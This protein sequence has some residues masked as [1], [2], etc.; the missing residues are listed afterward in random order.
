M[1]NSHL[2]MSKDSVRGRLVSCLSA[3]KLNNVE[4]AKTNGFFFNVAAEISINVVPVAQVK[5]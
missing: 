5:I 1:C 2:S 3:T 4:K